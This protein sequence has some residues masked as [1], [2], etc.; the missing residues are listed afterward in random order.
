MSS[1][2]AKKSTI[3]LCDPWGESYSFE[4]LK[5]S[6]PSHWPMDEPMILYRNRFLEDKD[7]K[8]DEEHKFST[9]ATLP[10]VLK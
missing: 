8:T 9:F 4:S 5:T 3:Y 1:S 10:Y 7:V 2:P 6:L